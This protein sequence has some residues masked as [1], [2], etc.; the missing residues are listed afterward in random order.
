MTRVT[1]MA[2]NF[3]ISHS[4]IFFNFAC[5]I[6]IIHN[7]PCTFGR[8]LL[9]HF[10]TNFWQWRIFWACS[11][12]VAMVVYMS[13]T[14]VYLA[15]LSVIS[16]YNGKSLL[17]NNYL[18]PFRSSAA[19]CLAWNPSIVPQIAL[20]PRFFQ[21]TAWNLFRFPLRRVSPNQDYWTE[22]TSR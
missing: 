3:L 4:L 9:H 8:V 11:N 13:P 22:G 17:F 14:H 12:P 10:T 21:L 5:R 15:S 6:F 20:M 16:E 1:K 7:S 19:D 18:D 2:F